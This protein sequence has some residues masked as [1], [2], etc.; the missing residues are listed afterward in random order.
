ML[1]ESSV[2]MTNICVDS[3]SGNLMMVAAFI[4]FSQALNKAPEGCN[5]SPWADMMSSQ[6]TQPSITVTHL[7]SQYNSLEIQD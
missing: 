3:V 6:I 1:V 2:H 7:H 5:A 4:G